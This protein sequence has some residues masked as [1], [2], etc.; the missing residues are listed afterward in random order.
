MVLQFFFYYYR[1]YEFWAKRK[2]TIANFNYIF[3]S[4]PCVINYNRFL[5][6]CMLI[7]LYNVCYHHTKVEIELAMNYCF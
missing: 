4:D 1:L 5:F 7:V 6:F 2:P 3:E